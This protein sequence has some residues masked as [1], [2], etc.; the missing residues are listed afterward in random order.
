M[1][2][3]IFDDESLAIRIHTAASAE[4]VSLIGRT[5][6]GSGG[7][8]YQIRDAQKKTDLLEG[9]HF[10]TLHA[11][12]CL[13]GVYVLR[14]KRV[15]MGKGDLPAYYRTYLALEPEHMGKGYGTLLVQKTRDFFIGE[16]HGAGLL[17][18]YIEADNLSSL[19]ASARAGYQSL[20]SFRAAMFSRLRA[21]EHP[22]A[23]PL[24]RKRSPL[25]VGELEALYA[26]HNLRDFEQSL[27]PDRYFVFEDESGI[28]AGVQI[29]TCD[30]VIERLPGLS[31]LVLVHLVSR[32]PVLRRIFDARYC[33]FLKFGNI[34]ARPGSESQLFTLMESVLARYRVGSA[35]IFYDPRSPVFQRIARAGSFGMLNSGVEITVHVMGSLIGFSAI[36]KQ[37]FKHR[38]VVLSPMDIG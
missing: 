4:M 30:W 14:R 23:Q 22:T 25:M 18:G 16:L 17:Y 3:L 9:S 15:A 33:R 21:R 37:R 5:V 19:R 8:R 38:P 13:A 34:Y 11:N 31:G 24:R 35:M 20:A 26:E 28:A 12:G 29:E 32:T 6:W 2:E 36:E 7:T 1:S 27:D 10:I